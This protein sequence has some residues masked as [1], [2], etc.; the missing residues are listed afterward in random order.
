MASDIKKPQSFIFNQVGPLPM[1][2]WMGLALG[3]VLVFSMWRSNSAPK[4]NTAA[5]A[6]GTTTD[7]LAYTL[8]LN[9][10]PNFID[11]DRTEINF[12]PA[13]GRDVPAG[14]DRFDEGFNVGHKQAFQQGFDAAHDPAFKKGFDEGFKK[15]QAAR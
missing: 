6:A 8:P 1:W 7:R 3:A 10:P 15:G 14:T 11:A 4:T 13:A 9:L 2:A 5:P 12:P